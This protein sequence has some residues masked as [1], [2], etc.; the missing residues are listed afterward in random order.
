MME[1]RFTGE[2]KMRSGVWESFSRLSGLVAL[3]LLLLGCT[4]PAVSSGTG[5]GTLAQSLPVAAQV[6]I[7]DQVIQLEV[8]ASPE[9]Q[10]K[11]LMYRDQLPDD[12]GMLF[13]FNPPRPVSFWMKNVRIN[14][15]MVFLRQ[16]QVKAIAADVPPCTAEPC[17]FYGPPD[18]VD[19]VIELRG[20][21][22]AELG[23]QVGDRL[24]VQPQP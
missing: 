11:G 16:G 15:D 2:S 19:Q 3:S 8:A 4:S 7:A 22:A 12:R 1:S 9:Q 18:A 21:R 10:A 20:G 17:P 5:E 6:K 23:I 24:V 14:L 13:P